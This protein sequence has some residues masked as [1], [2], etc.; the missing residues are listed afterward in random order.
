MKRAG[1]R[2]TNACRRPGDDCHGPL[3][4]FLIC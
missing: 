2:R 1:G 3:L 4:L